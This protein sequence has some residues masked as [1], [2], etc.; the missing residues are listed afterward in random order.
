[1]NKK[2]RQTKHT[3]V[4]AMS[5]A[6][7]TGRCGLRNTKWQSPDVSVHVHL[8]RGEKQ[9]SV[10]YRMCDYKVPGWETECV[11]TKCRA[12]ISLRKQHNGLM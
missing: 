1:M 11:V 2:S 5:A 12:G 6:G 10:G 3:H 7:P 9:A 8:H 4:G